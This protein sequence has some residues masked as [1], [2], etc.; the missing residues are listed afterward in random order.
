ML[1][2]GQDRLNQ[3][4][5]MNT[6]SSNRLIMIISR[7]GLMGVDY[8]AADVKLSLNSVWPIRALTLAK[9]MTIEDNRWAT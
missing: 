3:N 1:R 6:K 4:A 8:D 2:I 9:N 7:G 5:K